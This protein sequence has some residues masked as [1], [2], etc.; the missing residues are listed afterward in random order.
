[1]AMKNKVRSV[2]RPTICA[3]SSYEEQSAICSAP[4]NLRYYKEQSAIWRPTICT[5]PSY[6]EQSA[7]RLAPDN[8]HWIKNSAEQTEAA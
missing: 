3:R 8:L 5:R 4:D 7:I 1:M 2:R 6:E